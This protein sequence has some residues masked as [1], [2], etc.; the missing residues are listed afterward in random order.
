[1]AVLDNSVEQPGGIQFGRDVFVWGHNE[2]YAKCRFSIFHLLT[3]RLPRFQLGTGKRSNL[4][5]PQH[6]GPLP[7]PGLIPTVIDTE[8]PSSGTISPMPH[9]R[10]QRKPSQLA[11]SLRGC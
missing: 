4:P 11:P 6:L 5:T 2:W 10:L 9:S 7:Y 1:M 8:L 3:S